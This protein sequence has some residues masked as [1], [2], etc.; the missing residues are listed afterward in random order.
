MNHPRNNWSIDTEFLREILSLTIG[1]DKSY[2]K[3]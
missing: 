3:D 1:N 2:G